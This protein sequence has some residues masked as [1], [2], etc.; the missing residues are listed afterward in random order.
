[1]VFYSLSAFI[2][3]M[4]V[5]CKLQEVIEAHR[6]AIVRWFRTREYVVYYPN[7]RKPRPETTNR[8][9]EYDD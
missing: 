5:I 3:I 7:A 8:N 6:K 2:V 1:M 9:N 4:Y